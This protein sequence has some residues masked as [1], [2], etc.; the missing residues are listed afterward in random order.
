MFIAMAKCVQVPGSANQKK[1]LV[2][3]IKSIA[4]IIISHIKK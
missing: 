3:S 1:G 4:I 2:E